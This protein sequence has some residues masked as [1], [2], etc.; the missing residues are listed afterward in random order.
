MQNN[1]EIIARAIIIKDGKILLCKD[2]SA[3]HFFLPGGHIEFGEFSEEALRRELVEELGREA[4]SVEFIE[5]L[6]NIFV[7]NEEKRHEVNMIFKVEFGDYN[8]S[9]AED[10]IEFSWHDISNILEVNLLPEIMKEKILGWVKGKN[11]E[12]L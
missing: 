8:L 1:F 11:N 3:S 2:N 4:K 6:E 7:Q 9:S 12:E 5:V 10:H